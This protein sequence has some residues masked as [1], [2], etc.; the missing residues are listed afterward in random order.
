MTMLG[1]QLLSLDADPQAR[2]L[3]ASL[4][5][6]MTPLRLLLLLLALIF[7]SQRQLLAR[8]LLLLLDVIFPGRLLCLLRATA[9]MCQAWPGLKP[10]AARI[11]TLI[12]VVE[13]ALDCKL[14]F[15]RVTQKMNTSVTDV[16]ARLT[17]ARSTDL[18]KLVLASI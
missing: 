1:D 6:L 4:R 10:S 17:A 16:S 11:P 12:L 7:T 9:A 15:L 5:L 18:P 13:D 14:R 3:T 8:L 2:R